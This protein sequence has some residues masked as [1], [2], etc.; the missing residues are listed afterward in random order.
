MGGNERMI[1]TNTVKMLTAT[2]KFGRIFI[3]QRH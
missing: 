2:Y 1:P 3:T